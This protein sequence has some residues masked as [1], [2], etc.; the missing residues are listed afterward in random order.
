MVFA[1]PPISQ[2]HKLRIEKL[3]QHIDFDDDGGH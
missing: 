2:D 3:E 1:R